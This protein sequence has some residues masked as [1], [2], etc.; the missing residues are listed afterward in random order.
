MND[1]AGSQPDNRKTEKRMVIITAFL[2]VLGG[3]LFQKPEGDR[4]SISVLIALSEAVCA[5]LGA[6]FIYHLISR[7]S[8]GLL[9]I[10]ISL[11]VGIPIGYLIALAVVLWLR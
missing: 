11:L 1:P 6:Y 7:R 3:W 8:G 4:D 9:K 5:T 2:V 10:L